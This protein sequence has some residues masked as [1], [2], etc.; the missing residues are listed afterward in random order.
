M[1][2][3]RSACGNRTGS[4]E[5]LAHLDIVDRDVRNSRRV[6]SSWRMSIR[7]TSSGVVVVEGIACAEAT[8]HEMKPVE[9]AIA[10]PGKRR[11]QIE[12]RMRQD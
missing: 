6:G 11:E 1:G 3:C 12:L 9:Q 7:G 10:E 5:Q 4:P 8:R 2:A